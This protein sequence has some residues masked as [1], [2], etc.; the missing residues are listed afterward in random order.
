MSLKGIVTSRVWNVD[1]S[2]ER[3][4]GTRL[5]DQIARFKSQAQKRRAH[6]MGSGG[7]TRPLNSVD[8]ADGGISKNKTGNETASGTSSKMSGS[9]REDG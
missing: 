2:S 5:D 8:R 4:R 7:L 1:G 9:N 6:S 3:V